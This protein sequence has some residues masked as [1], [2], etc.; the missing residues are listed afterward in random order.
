[1]DLFSRENIPVQDLSQDEARIELERL[2]REISHHDKLYHDQ[3]APQISDAEYDRLRQRNDQIEK[4]FPAL[5]LKSSPSKKVGAKSS[6][7]FS[8]VTHTKPML[9][10]DNAFS[11]EDVAEFLK[12]LQRFLGNSAPIEFV[13][14]PKFDGLSCAL[15]YEKGKLLQAA[16]RGDGSV[17]EDITANVKTIKDIPQALQGSTFPDRIE[18][19][20]EIYMDKQDF[21]DLNKKREAQGEAL[22]ANPRNS[23]AGSVRQLDSSITASRPLKFFA[24]AVADTEGM[25]VK[26]QKDILE[27]LQGWGFQVNPNVKVCGSVEELIKHYTYIEESRA[28]LPYDIDGVVYKVND[29]EL[30]KRLGF[31]ARSP[32]WA[33]AHKFPAEQAQT[34]LNDITIQVGRTGVLTPVAE[35]EP[36]TV[37]GVVVARATLHN[38]DEIE[39]KDVRIGDTVIIQRAGDV[40]PQVVES[41]QD[42]AHE[43][44][45]KY[46]FPTKCPV[47]DSDTFQEPGQVA[48][49][50]S[51]GLICKAQAALR[52][53]HF[54]SKGAFDIDGLGL[55]HIEAFYEEGLIKTP[56]DLFR[57]QDKDKGSLTPLKN[58][59]GW[60]PKSALNLFQAIEDRKVI[61]LNRFIYALGIP[62]IGQ[63]LAKT[64]AY[65]FGSYVKFREILEQ[66]AE[67][68][69]S[70]A[71]LSLVNIDGIGDK[72]VADLL[73]FAHE[74]HNKAVLDDLGALLTI[75]D[76]EKV[77]TSGSPVAGKV[78]VF[79]GT[80]TQVSRQE[81]KAR[82]ESLGAKVAS[83]VSSK[84]DY[85]I[86]GESPGSKAKKAAELGVTIL[87]EQQWLDLIG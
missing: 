47:C 85:V 28:N 27:T 74:P 24:Y 49:L 39:R 20:G 14:E 63:T 65:E 60:G 79:T 51:G 64:L 18:I 33:I 69:T 34:I 48:T 80:L 43:S 25:S 76:M 55:R 8:K 70:D 82:A 62:Q 37:G 16:T 32:R 77:D 19:R 35:L 10:L 66:A 61:P 45:S 67:D 83:A 1:M 71:Y 50:C 36:I 56:G 78:V 13:A 81:A 68:K 26:S 46:E 12:R 58:R 21:L 5:V 73:A 44:R 3:D 52:L 11:D 75:E 2:S 86:V 29:L 17:G 9:S 40:I 54:V 4:R 84:T 38:K 53:H 23:A 15:S 7:G 72:V 31:V 6:K 22:F 87:T 42:K 41:I 30:Q 59:E 57:L